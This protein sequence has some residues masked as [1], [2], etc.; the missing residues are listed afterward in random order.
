MEEKRKM[1]DFILRIVISILTAIVTTLSTTS[2]MRVMQTDDSLLPPAPS[3]LYPLTYS[4][5]TDNPEGNPA[6]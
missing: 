4:M 1:W 5:P 3:S 6:E 2:C